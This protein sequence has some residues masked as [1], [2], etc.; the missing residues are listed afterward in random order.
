M[1]N[2]DFKNILLLYIIICY[3]D[4]GK[5]HEK[6]LFLSDCPL[7]FKIQKNKIYYRIHLFDVLDVSVYSNTYIYIP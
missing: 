4:A 2:Y 5:R 1:L 6:Y 7:I 3:V